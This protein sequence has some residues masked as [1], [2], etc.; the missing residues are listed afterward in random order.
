VHADQIQ[1]YLSAI[2]HLFSPGLVKQV[3]C[4]CSLSYYHA[5]TLRCRGAAFLLPFSVYERGCVPATRLVRTLTLGLRGLATLGPAAAFVPDLPRTDAAALLA[6]RL[7]F[8]FA[9]AFS[10]CRAS[11]CRQA[12]TQ[13][14]WLQTV[15][16]FVSRPDCRFFF[17]FERLLISRRTDLDSE[18]PATSLRTLTIVYVSIPYGWRDEPWWLKQTYVSGVCCLS[19]EEHDLCDCSLD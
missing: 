17:I 10:G 3:V 16:P 6:E 2:T 18:P 9:A 15:L 14:R 7:R 11:R 19:L 4:I 12:T 13:L 1:R 5:G 8:R